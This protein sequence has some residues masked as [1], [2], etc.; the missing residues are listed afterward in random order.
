MP[1]SPVAIDPVISI[2]IRG[3]IMWTFFSAS[4]GAVMAGLAFSAAFGP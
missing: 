2:T 3:F 4:V 1:I